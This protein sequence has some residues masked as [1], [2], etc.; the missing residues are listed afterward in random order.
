MSRISVP[1]SGGVEVCGYCGRDSTHFCDGCGKYI[2]DRVV[3]VAKGAAR[4]LGITLGAVGARS[5]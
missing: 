3:C 1:A 5:E 2:C 4:S